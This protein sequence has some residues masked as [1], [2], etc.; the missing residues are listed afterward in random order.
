[1]TDIRLRQARQAVK[2]R[3]RILQPQILVSVYIMSQV[4]HGY[5]ITGPSCVGCCHWLQLDLRGAQHPSILRTGC[6]R[7]LQTLL[8][9]ITKSQQ[10]LLVFQICWKL[11]VLH[12]KRLDCPVNSPCL[13]DPRAAP[14]SDA[15]QADAL[16]SQRL[17]D[18]SPPPPP[19]A[20]EEEEYDP[21]ST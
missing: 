17:P 8:R 13:T 1:M 15:P 18:P 11:Q 7:A 16:P 9:D 3:S 14:P 19:A 12:A 5:R 20:T 6:G 4:V 2:C 21:F 10:W